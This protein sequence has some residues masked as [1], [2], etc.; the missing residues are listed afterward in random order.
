MATAWGVCYRRAAFYCDFLYG[1]KDTMERI[2]IKK[3]FLFTVGSVCR[4]KRFTTGWQT[5]RWWRISWNGGGEV[6]EWLRVSTQWSNDGTSVSMLVEDMSR[7]KCFFFSRFEYHMFYVLD[8]F[9]TY[10]L[11]L[12]H[13]GILASELGC[14]K[15]WPQTQNWYFLENGSSSSD[16]DWI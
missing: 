16:F 5:F 7:N 2:F 8:P 13:M 9:V 3:C 15:R 10:L 1:G 4:V 14:L 6:A 11:T 12:P